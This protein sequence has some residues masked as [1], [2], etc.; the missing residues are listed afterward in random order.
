MFRLIQEFAARGCGV[1][2]ISSDLEEVV[3]LCDRAIV[4]R[5]GSVVG[6][7][8][9]SDLTRTAILNLAYGHTSA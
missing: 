8:A 6:T 7:L 1:L 5:E 3:E 9:R 2:F 4:M